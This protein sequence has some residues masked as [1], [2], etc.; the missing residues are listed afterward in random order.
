MSGDLRAVPARWL[1]LPLVLF[2]AAC[3][4]DAATRVAAPADAE[5]ASQTAFSGNGKLEVTV[6]KADR[7]PAVGTVVTIVVSPPAGTSDLAAV[8]YGPRFWAEVGIN[9]VALFE[10]LPTGLRAC[11]HA[12]S[13]VALETVDLTKNSSV[14]L[15]PPPQP[16]TILEPKGDRTQGAVL[17]GANL[18]AVPFSPGNYLQ[19]CVNNPPLTLAAQGGH[20]KITLQ[21]T[22]S[23]SVDVKVLDLVGNV[24][25][26]VQRG[27]VTG[28]F[29]Q[30][31][32]AQPI[33][34]CNQIPWLRADPLCDTV[35]T[36]PGFLHSTRGTPNPLSVAQGVPFRVEALDR[37]SVGDSD[38]V[39][40]V[41]TQGYTGGAVTGN[42][43][44]AENL[45]CRGGSHPDDHI[46]HEIGNA[47]GMDI[48]GLLKY[49]IGV[50]YAT[51]LSPDPSRV[52]VWFDMTADDGTAT[53][54]T[55]TVPKGSNQT[56]SFSMNFSARVV[57]GEYRCT[58]TGES[59]QLFNLGASADVYC[60]T[61]SAPPGMVR[62]TI[63][64]RGI[65][66]WDS[67]EF[68]VKTNPD[69]GSGDSTWDPDRSGASRAFV[70]VPTYD[71]CTVSGGN[72]DRL[73][74][75]I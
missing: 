32:A 63:I 13:D 72:D 29:I 30:G 10:N 47:S 43:L 71:V 42:I 59:G 38:D 62:V 73:A 60:D 2:L 54:S 39:E 28:G 11:V 20:T 26:D 35:E 21:H 52:S 58:K 57:G 3:A 66:D 44:V 37:V 53:F 46:E 4:D 16:A 61:A 68:N 50:G 41:A 40:L 1:A 69:Q 51:T 18:R 8:Q 23:A 49:S 74:I 31:V 6:H 24:R 33:F 55:R 75:R 45:V 65:P 70:P 34:T 22:L 12:R 67:H 15:Y 19:H 7:S 17:T 56:R 14:V 48:Q 25:G 27:V 36:P 64:Q 5:L 9:G